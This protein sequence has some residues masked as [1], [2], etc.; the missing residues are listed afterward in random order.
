M[1]G[2]GKPEPSKRSAVLSGAICWL[3]L[4]SFLTVGCSFPV[5]SEGPG[6]QRGEGPGGRRQ[7]LALNPREEWEAGQRAYREIVDKYR[8]QLLPAD[9]PR[10][11]RVRRVLSRIVNAARIRPL[12]REI[13]LRI[14]G[15]IFKWEANVI[16]D[17]QINAFCLPGGKVFVF[18]GI[19]KVIGDNDDYL[20]TVLAHEVAHAL[21]HHA[22]ERIAREH[23]VGGILSSLAYDRMQESEADHIGVFLMTFAG[24]N[25]EAAVAFWQRMERVQ[26]EHGRVPEFLSDHPSDAHRIERLRQSARPGGGGQTGL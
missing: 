12:Q 26:G 19:L 20:A 8:D 18:T 21:A 4:A 23:S 13:N 1:T 5:P 14:R 25:P 24:Y 15:Y 17:R 2:A 11:Q 10:V 22:S 3:L 9:D 7:P 6:R 16:E